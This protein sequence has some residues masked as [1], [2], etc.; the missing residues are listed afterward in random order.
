[1]MSDVLTFF[2]PA[3]QERGKAQ[4]HKQTNWSGRTSSWLL[5]RFYILDLWVRI[6]SSC[7]ANEIT[8][9]STCSHDLGICKGMRR[10]A[11]E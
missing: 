4:A 1:M 11:A 9:H 10:K 2:S 7:F 3:K 8:M 6:L 5:S